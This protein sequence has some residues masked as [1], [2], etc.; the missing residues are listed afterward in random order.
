MY[1]FV[2]AYDADD[3]LDVKDKFEDRVDEEYEATLPPLSVLMHAT[4]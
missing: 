3:D 2:E 1:D 4:K